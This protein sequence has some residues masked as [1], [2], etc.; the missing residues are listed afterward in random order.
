MLV[1]VVCVQQV[2]M[3]LV[4]S[5]FISEP[6]SLFSPCISLIVSVSLYKACLCTYIPGHDCICK[7]GFLAYLCLWQSLYACMALLETYIYIS[8]SCSNC[9]SITIGENL[10]FCFTLYLSLF[11][12]TPIHLCL[13]FKLPLSLF[14]TFTV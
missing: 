9:F 7:S 5:K 13:C 4:I 2:Y 3:S 10:S 11:L 12:R 6:I 1:I 14:Q 8:I